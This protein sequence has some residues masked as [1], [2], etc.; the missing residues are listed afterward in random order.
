MKTKAESEFYALDSR[1]KEMQNRIEKT[2]NETSVLKAETAEDSSKIIKPD[3]YE[4]IGEKAR[5]ILK[6]FGRQEIKKET[7]VVTILLRIEHQIDIADAFIKE[8]ENKKY[9]KGE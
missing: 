9:D 2:Q 5:D 3:K 7:P 8:K 1:E 6:Q 4:L